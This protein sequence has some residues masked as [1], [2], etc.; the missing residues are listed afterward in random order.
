M[1]AVSIVVLPLQLTTDQLF[2]YKNV[3]VLLVRTKE[4]Q[5]FASQQKLQKNYF[6]DEIRCSDVNPNKWLLAYW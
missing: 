3:V 6:F 5:T 1:L 2:S 4:V